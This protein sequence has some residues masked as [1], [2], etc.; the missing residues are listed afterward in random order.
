[1]RYVGT[2]YRPP[3][4]AASL[5]IQ[6]T[7]GCSSNTCT[8]CS[9]YKDKPF[10]IRP[11][12]D[13]LEDLEAAAAHYPATEKLFLADGDALCL[14]TAHLVQICEAAK[15]L[16]PRLKRITAYATAQDIL[17]KT[18]EALRTLHEAGIT[19]LYIGLESG[20]DAVLRAICK[21]TTA[22]RFIQAGRQ[23]IDCGFELSVT[24]IA[25]LQ[26]L[27]PDEDAAHDSARVISAVVPHYVSYLTLYLEPGAPLYDAW[28]AGQF[29]LPTPA[30]TLTEIRT[31]IN[32]V[33]A[34]GCVFR[35][36]HASNYVSLRGTLND[37]RNSIIE[38]IDHA[39]AQARFR[40]EAWRAL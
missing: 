17:N 34:P 4:E 18:P 30:D 15:R 39:L 8:F 29:H 22:D 11:L 38:T 5:I 20:N 12:S 1:M 19:M 6:V 28:Q 3:S 32:H 21:N 31:F 40:D 16:F 2:V 10:A 27:A 33:D 14:P 24:L 35:S 13:C 25:G 37:D 26:A 36:N 9:M 23:A 7:I